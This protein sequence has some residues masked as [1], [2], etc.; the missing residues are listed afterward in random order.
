MGALLMKRNDPTEW[1]PDH[2]SHVFAAIGNVMRSNRLYP[3]DLLRL[4]QG[5]GAILP[6]HTVIVEHRSGTITGDRRG[7]YFITIEG[8]VF[9]GG[10]SF[11]SGDLEA[12]AQRYHKGTK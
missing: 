12:R 8:P 4:P 1:W 2:I 7:R 11:N 5:P 6:K 9:F 3:E 10:W